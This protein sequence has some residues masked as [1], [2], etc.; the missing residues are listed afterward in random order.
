MIF[1]NEQVDK[2]YDV[3]GIVQVNKKQNAY[4]HLY[5]EKGKELC[6]FYVGYD[7]AN[8]NLLVET[9]INDTET[10]K[11]KLGEFI[12]EQKL[13]LKNRKQK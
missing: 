13:F 2:L 6:N 11:Q 12:K 10:I 3:N 4:P 8:E 9:T 5:D 7:E 1:I